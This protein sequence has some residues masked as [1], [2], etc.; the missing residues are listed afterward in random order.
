MHGCAAPHLLPLVFH[1]QLQICLVTRAP[2]PHLLGSY[3]H[4][5]AHLEAA[6]ILVI[7]ARLVSQ[8]LFTSAL[9]WGQRGFFPS[10][11]G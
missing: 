2:K 7:P 10:L 3:T 4:V 6:P 9:D 8:S 5:T 1:I 11:T